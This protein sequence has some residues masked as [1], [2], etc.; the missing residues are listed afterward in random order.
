MLR[1]SRFFLSD[2]PVHMVVSGN[3]RQVVFAETDDYQA[4]LDFWELMAKPL[5]R[6]SWGDKIPYGITS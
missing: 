2:I 3:S 4:Y 1:K 5:Q 6:Q